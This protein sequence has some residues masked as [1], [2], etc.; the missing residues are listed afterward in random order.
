MSC[1]RRRHSDWGQNPGTL[2]FFVTFPHRLIMR[3]KEIYILK[4]GTVVTPEF[5]D[6]PRNWE[7]LGG[8][9]GLN[10]CGTD[11]LCH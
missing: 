7:P 11:W 2:L 5:P 1:S 3:I 8:P 9:G 6:V 4:K 10:T